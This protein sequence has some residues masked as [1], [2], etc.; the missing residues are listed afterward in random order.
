[1]KTLLLKI[2]LIGGM[3]LGFASSS[4]GQTF[5][6]ANEAPDASIS[7]TLEITFSSGTS[8]S[9]APYKTIY[10]AKSDW[11]EFVTLSTQLTTPP[12]TAKDSRLQINDNIL[13]IDLSASNLTYSQDYIVY[14][15]TGSILLD[16]VAW[17]DLS[18]YQNPGWTF[19]TESAPPPSISTLSPTNNSE[20]IPVDQNLTIT[21]N[22]DIQ[23]GSGAETLTILDGSGSFQTFAV[24]DL[25]VD[26]TGDQLS[27][28]HDNFSYFTNYYVLMD[29]GF[30]ESSTTFAAF[31]GVSAPSAWN[32]TTEPPPL[33]IN[34][35]TPADEATD[36]SLDGDLIINFSE[37]ISRG[38]GSMTIYNSD[39]DF[40]T[41]PASSTTYLNLTDNQLT[42]SHNAFSPSTNY[43][44]LMDDGFIS[45]FSGITD[46]A[47][48]NFTTSAGAPSW[49]TTPSLSNQSPSEV[50]LSGRADQDGNYYYVIVKLAESAP[51]VDQILNGLKRDGTAADINGSDTLIADQPFSENIDISSLTPGNVYSIH[52]VAYNTG[53]LSGSIVSTNIDLVLPILNPVT[54]D[55]GT[56]NVDINTSIIL[57]YSKEV[58]GTTGVA[59]DNTNIDGYILLKDG[60]GTEIPYEVSFNNDGNVLTLSP[61][62]W[63]EDNTTYTVSFTTL[64]ED[65]FGNIQSELPSDRTF[66][67]EN[68]IF[69]LGGDSSW[70]TLTN[71]EDN[72]DPNGSSILIPSGFSSY[73]VISSGSVSLNNVYIEPGASLT[74]TG[75]TI[76]VSEQFILQSS[77]VANAAYVPQGGT[78]TVTDPAKVRIEQ[79]ITNPSDSYY[80]SAP[81]I[82]AT[83]GNTGITDAVVYYDNATDAYVYLNDDTD[84]LEHGRGYVARNPGDIAFTDSIFQGDLT[85]DVIRTAGQGLGWNLIGNPYTASIDLDQLSIDNVNNTF[86]IYRNDPGHYGTY[87][88]TGASVNLDPD[89]PDILPSNTSFWVRVDESATEG[90]VGFTRANTQSNL[91][92]YL[93]S[94]SSGS[95][96]PILKLASNFN[97]I[98]DETALVM[99]PEATTGYDNNFDSYK[100]LSGKNNICDLYTVAGTSQLAINSLP[101]L[102]EGVSINLGFVQNTS[103]ME[104]C[105]ITMVNNSLSSNVSVLLEDKYEDTM[106]D[107]TNGSPYV[108]SS[109]KKGK[110]N[111]RFVIHFA[112]SIPTT[113][114]KKEVNQ[115]NEKIQIY[116]SKSEI[117]TYLVELSNPEY[118]LFDI[119]GKLLKSGR[120]NAGSRNVI[121]VSQKGGIIFVVTHSEGTKTFK[122]VF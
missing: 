62:V 28:T 73:P 7:P 40:Q 109:T 46:N 33:T 99:V 83:K 35:T 49:T 22:E 48:W 3:I 66:T 94:T 24:S 59:L 11:S 37:N 108:F 63:L 61:D 17:D 91:H 82:G 29:E 102:E 6:P 52:V 90:S 78:L 107:I 2:G 98:K 76:T 118:K 84:A 21:F 19:T 58:F 105:E 113:M 69:W 38:I 5:S 44:V 64:V 112:G 111:D 41:I 100:K 26:A 34:S 56:T 60:S 16:G 18:D 75:A 119:N 51:S 14:T 79:I 122:T 39:G 120:L 70:G 106:A 81:V 8:I 110:V 10:V 116:S 114:N 27:I 31:G 103:V 71:W 30:V 12:F 13:T 77:D 23:L 65:Q 96:Y 25:N 68:V 86:W 97:G 20:N 95:K 9:F 15:Q 32:F 80:I 92:T 104:N 88:T 4:F 50:T 43:Y 117:I 53:G 121:P 115:D 42:I 57:P 36:V 89:N 55:N 87:N 101:S 67:T 74:N 47:T 72:T 1:M 93:K 45:G 54:P 85:T